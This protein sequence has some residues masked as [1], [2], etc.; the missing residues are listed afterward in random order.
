M[1][2]W[3][4]IREK[5][6]WGTSLLL[7]SG[8]LGFGML[9]VLWAGWPQPQIGNLDHSSAPIVLSEDTRIQQVHHKLMPVT[10]VSRS[11]PSIPSTEE[12][13]GLNL[14]PAHVQLLVD[15]NASS[16]MEL[17]TLPG[18]GMVLADRIVSYRSTYGGFQHVG[19]LVNV[20]GIGEKRLRRLKPF[21]TVAGIVGKRKS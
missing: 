8:M 20:S 10:S 11:E 19:D 16:Q 7:K 2:F 6:A 14:Q 17:K 21:V 9:V 12:G 1:T 4:K 5:P 3:E 15:L 13:K 18:I